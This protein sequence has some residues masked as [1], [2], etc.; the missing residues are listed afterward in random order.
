MSK[1]HRRFSH[2]CQVFRSF[3]RLKKN[4]TVQEDI[5]RALKENLVMAKNHM[6][7][8]EDKARFERQFVE[9]D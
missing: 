9:G 3:R 5:L 4:I 2:T 8:Q 1:I 6:K 7:K